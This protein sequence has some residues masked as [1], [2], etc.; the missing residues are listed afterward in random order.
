MTARE[1]AYQEW[2]ILILDVKGRVE[3]ATEPTT[4]QWRIEQD[5]RNIALRPG[6]SVKVQVRTVSAWGDEEHDYEME[7]QPQ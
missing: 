3:E 2:R 1:E 7:G 6:D 5:L 4:F